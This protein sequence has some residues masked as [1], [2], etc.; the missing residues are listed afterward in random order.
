M[1]RWR[2][3]FGYPGRID[4]HERV[5]L[6]L[7][8]IA[9]QADIKLN[10]NALGS[11]DSPAEYDVTALLGPRNELVMATESL[12]SQEGFS[13]D[14]ALEVRCTAYLR[15]VSAW[16]ESAEAGRVVVHATGEVVGIADKP[17][18]VYLVLDRLPLAETQVVASGAIQAFHLSAGPLALESSGPV[19]QVDLVNGAVVWY[20][21]KQSLAFPAA[22]K[23]AQ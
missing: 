16:A 20:T 3:R 15:G 13:A 11:I 19:V 6:T 21:I 10:G 7:E 5:W 2:R 12:K 18:D 9:T 22:G 1:V 14:V 8:G 4:A 23:E 17:L